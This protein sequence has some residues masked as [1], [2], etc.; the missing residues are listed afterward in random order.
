V[1]TVTEIVYKPV[2]HVV[3]DGEIGDFVEKRGMSDCIECFTEIHR[4]DYYKWV[5]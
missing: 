5:G 2:I 4:D 1:R 3:W